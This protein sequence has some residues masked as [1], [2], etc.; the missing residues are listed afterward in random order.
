MRRNITVSRS[1]VLIHIYALTHAFATILCRSFSLADEYVLTLITIMMIVQICIDRK[2]GM[3]V[4][5]CAIVFGNLAGYLLGAATA[6]LIALI[7]LPAS[8]TYAISTFFTTE[9]VGYTI[10]GLSYILP[11]S[12]E[13]RKVTITWTIAAIICVFAARVT[14]SELHNRGYFKTIEHNEGLFYFLTSFC[15]MT[16]L[17]LIFLLG[18]NMIEKHRMSREQEKR[19]LAQFRYLRLSQQVNPHF[20]FNSLNVLDC[21]VNEGDSSKASEYIQKLS[22]I[23]RYMLSHEEEVLVRLRDEMEF[24]GQYLDLMKLRFQEGLEIEIDIDENALNKELVPCSVQLL[25]ENA[26]KHNAINPA[27]PLKIS[28]QAS[29]SEICVSNNVCPKLTPVNST[30]KGLKYIRQQFMDI[31]SKEIEIVSNDRI[32]KVTLPLL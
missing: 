2:V 6:N 16:V 4:L 23:Y 7:N 31:S 24:T 8:L 26:T 19:H 13:N 1:S 21:L 15:V 29:E 27:N 14:L 18:F 10:L 9:L 5:S 11:G 17:V 28:I 30:G 32:F 25:I 3:S 20:L 22:G 12:K